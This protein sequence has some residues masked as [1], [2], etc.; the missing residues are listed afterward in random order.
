M[1]ELAA[2]QADVSPCIGGA[3]ADLVA[4]AGPVESQA[5]LSLAE[6]DLL[7]G[8]DP[9][10]LV[11]GGDGLGTAG[12]GL[13]VCSEAT[14]GWTRRVRIGKAPVEREGNPNRKTALEIS[15]RAYISK[16]DGNV[17]NPAVGTEFDLLDEAY[18]FYNLYSWEVGFGIRFAKS[19]LNVNRRKCM[20]EIVCGCASKPLRESTRSTRCGCT[21]RIRL[22]RSS[23]NG[24]YIS[25]HRDAHNHN[26]SATCSEKMH[27][28][29]HRHI[30]RYTK[31]LVKKLREN[32]ISLGKVFSIV[33]SFFGSVDNVPFTKRSLKTLCCK[34]NKEQSDSDARK[35]MDILGE[36]KA[37]DP[38]F[39]YTIQV[40]EE[41]RIKSIMWVNG[42]SV[43]QY[44][45]FGDA[46][47]FDTTYRTNLYDMSFGLFVGV[48]NH[49]QSIIF[50]GVMVR[51]EKEDTFKWVFREFIRMMG[52]STRRQY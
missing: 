27:W 21:A 20:Q 10:L 51:D 14:S 38:E 5:S 9:V 32:N 11:E 1:D 52:G 23:D 41:S 22:L 7:R 40:D 34:L 42:R 39:N 4:L 33:G 28:Q 16:R 2:Q 49:F 3:T 18:Q 37:N 24:W 44:R 46:I 35:T 47:T 13:H 45:C 36:M 15:M 25:E 50:G 12:G 31:D 29:S 19:R 30:D 17:V 48:N 43:D 8:G 26:L 6:A